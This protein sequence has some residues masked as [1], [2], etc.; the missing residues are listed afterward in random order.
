MTSSVQALSRADSSN[1][2]TTRGRFSICSVSTPVKINDG[3]NIGP[4]S[5]DPTFVG[6]Y[7]GLESDTHEQIRP[8]GWILAT[9]KKTFIR[10][11]SPDVERHDS[12]VVTFVDEDSRFN[13][14]PSCKH[15]D[16]SGS[17]ILC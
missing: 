16:R 3:P 13:D 5:P 9:G 14:T 7:I 1:A 8:G 12:S 10:P 6:D 17:S 2:R 11:T 4:A 15:F